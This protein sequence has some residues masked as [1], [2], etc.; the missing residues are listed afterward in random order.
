VRRR[1][2]TGLVLALTLVGFASAT[3]EP[4]LQEE[5]E[6]A[7]VLVDMRVVD[8]RGRPLDG[9]QPGN[10]DVRVDGKPVRVT[11]LDF[12]SAAVPGGQTG[13]RPP[14]RVA[15]NSAAPQGRRIVLFFQRSLVPSRIL[16]LMHLQEQVERFV[17]GLAPDDQVA[18]FLFDSSLK[19]FSDFTTDRDV[20]LELVRESIVVYEAPQAEPWRSPRPGGIGEHY[21][22]A[23][24]KDAATPEQGLLVVSRALEHVP[25]AKSLLY[26]G[27]GLGRYETG[28]V[29]MQPEW[30]RTRES[31]SESRTALFALDFTQADYHT[32]ELPLTAVALETGGFYT[33]TFPF[34][35]IAMDE[36]SRAIATHYEL[37][38]E[39]PDLKPGL[40]RIRIKLR[41]ARGVVYHRE[42]YRDTP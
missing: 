18:V 17:T 33:K 39:K 34:P 1:V 28:I 41:G 2:A 27:W 13:D 40:H 42:S 6:T 32:L 10:F 24:A 14:A 3:Q 5:I 23:D 7:R 16:G 9:L 31:M 38:F 36:V 25:G 21:D 11:S 22:P 15:P 35:S 20:V 12:V 30:G 8:T 4:V 19:F 26:L 37:A 29:G